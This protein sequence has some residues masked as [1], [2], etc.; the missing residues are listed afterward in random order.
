V[1]IQNAVDLHQ[2]GTATGTMNFFR[3]LGSAVAVAIFGAIVLGGIA[4]P[5]AASGHLA[6]AAAHAGGDLAGAFRRL[7]LAATG[8]LALGLAWLLA[9]AERPLRGGRTLAWDGTTAV[10]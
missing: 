6:E 10:E 8:G 7:F 2:L 1:A 4:A 5:D 9:M 3:S